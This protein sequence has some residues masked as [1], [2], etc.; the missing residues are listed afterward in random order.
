MLVAVKQL[1]IAADALDAADVRV[2][3][4]VKQ[5]LTADAHDADGAC[6]LVAVKQG[7]PGS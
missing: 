5:G 4:V 6:R 2:L 1:G 3:V 7:G